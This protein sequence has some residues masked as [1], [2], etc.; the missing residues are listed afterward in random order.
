MTEYFD[1]LETREPAQRQAE[2]FAELPALIAHA[3]ANAPAYARLLAGVDAA[4][5]N[6]PAVLAALPVTRKSDLIEAQ[7]GYELNS[8]VITASD[9]M[10]AATTRMR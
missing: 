1:A 8:K 7:R 5:V 4:T 9:E 2:L 10:M 3:Q 6:S